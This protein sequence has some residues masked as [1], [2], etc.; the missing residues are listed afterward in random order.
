L[1]KKFTILSSLPWIHAND[2]SNRE[3]VAIIGEVSTIGGGILN[4]L[5]AGI[6]SRETPPDILR[7]MERLGKKLA[8][9]GWILRSGGARGADS[10]FHK[11]CLD[12]SGDAEIFTADHATPESLELA[13]KYHPNWAACSDYAKRLHARNGL[14]LLGKYLELPVE[15]IV[16]WTPDAKPVGGTGQAL[17]MAADYNIKVRN[18]ADVEVLENV[19]KYLEG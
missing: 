16:C 8:L 11:G 5:Y 12:V 7:V 13:A 1:Y 18:L 3:K 14:I 9:E 2:T 15:M 10:A 6:G 19:L 17:R 4:R